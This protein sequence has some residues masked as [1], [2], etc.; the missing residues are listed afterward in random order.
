MI[1]TERH[2]GDDASARV[3]EKLGMAHE[4]DLDFRGR[5][6]RLFSLSL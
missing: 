3:A 1:E 4:R 2:P 5:M 6:T